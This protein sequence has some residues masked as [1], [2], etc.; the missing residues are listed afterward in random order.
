MSE[1]GP[2]TAVAATSRRRQLDDWLV[3]LAAAGITAH[4]RR[5]GFEWQLFVPE[6]LVMAARA[7]LREFESENAHRFARQPAVID[8]GPSPGG[9]AMGLALL[10]LH[11]ASFLEPGRVYWIRRG[12]S[13]A[14]YILD[15]EWWRTITALT[16]HADAPHVLGN[17]AGAFVFGGAVCR[18]LGGGVGV[19]AILATGFL[20]NL[21]NAVWRGSGHASIGAS[22]AVFG[23]VGLLAGVQLMRRLHLAQDWR[24]SWLPLGAAVAILAMIGVSAESDF[25]AHLFG[26][27]AGLAVGA[28]LA[29]FGPPPYSRFAQ[30]SCA[31]ATPLIVAG[32]WAAALWR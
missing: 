12:R 4:S 20:G 29:A 10:A 31:I 9:I 27:V 3:V 18:I 7:H 25:L 1:G 22:T 14:F 19:F 11:A 5:I 2:L 28:G 26:L 32:A 8:L 6:E 24:R 16:L 17:A 23:A 13:A 30:W 15:G 21:M